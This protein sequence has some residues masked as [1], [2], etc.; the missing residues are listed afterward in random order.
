MA[1]P[2]CLSIREAMS[3]VERQLAAK[4]AYLSAQ[5][6]YRQGERQSMLREFRAVM[7]EA[8][9]LPSLKSPSPTP[10]HPISPPD[11]KAPSA[12]PKGP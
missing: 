8:S 10:V 11:P 4:E 6:E 9:E 5:A 1:A 2:P 3:H 12:A 7:K